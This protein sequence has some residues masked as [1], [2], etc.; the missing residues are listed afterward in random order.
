MKVPHADDAYY[1]G[2]RGDDFLLVARA[3]DAMTHGY[4]R[5]FLGSAVVF[6]AGLLVAALTIDAGPQERTGPERPQGGS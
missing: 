3:Q 2:L 6:T 1:A 4:T 5:A